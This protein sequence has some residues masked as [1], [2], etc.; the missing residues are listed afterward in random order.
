[1]DKERIQHKLK[2]D[3]ERA[4][5]MLKWIVFACLVGA[6][7]GPFG[8]LFCFLMNYVTK[9]RTDHP[10][11]L[12]F[13]PFG[14]VVITFMYHIF[15]KRNVSYSASGTN[16]VL[17]AIQ[18]QD[19]IP[20]RMAPLIFVSTIMSHLV[21]ASVGR[22]GAALQMGG[23]IGNAIGKLFKFS[24]ND[25]H[26]IIMCGMSAAFSAVFGTPMA[27]AVFSME[28][29]SVGIMHYAALVPCVISAF[30]ARAIARYFGF[31]DSHFIIAGYPAFSLKTAAIIIGFAAVCGIMSMVFC[32]LLNRSEKICEDKIKSPYIRALIGG[33]LVLLMTLI[34]GGQTYNGTGA[35]I[36][37]D[38]FAG[39]TV[40][41]AAFLP[42]MIF[43]VVSI[44]AGYKG[45]EIVPS[46]CI[47]TS[48]GVFFGWIFGFSPEA[49]VLLAAVGM[50]AF[51]CGVT[52]C[53]ITSLLIC[54]ELFGMDAMPYFLLAIAISY[55][56]SGYYGLYT[57]QKIL[58]SKYK[59]NYINKKIH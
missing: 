33:T 40:F 18:A 11:I 22:E 56:I 24:E 20:L 51:F 38:V 30:I 50:G 48:L 41:A 2:H 29:V 23:S 9:L 3:A 42:K 15:R 44:L 10:Y 54:L 25:K 52:N 19:D 12:Y 55:M 14:A 7:V 35:A 8:T 21:G 47:G 59:S 39:N 43:T 34:S 31:P 58:Y 13:L 6:V 45:G 4:F 27:A 37:E 49:T 26:T 1:M 36:I 32:F 53:P 5:A 46:F 57:S 28:V 17:S 16:L